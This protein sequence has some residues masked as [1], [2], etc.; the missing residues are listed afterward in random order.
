MLSILKKLILSACIVGI[1]AFN[2]RAAITLVNGKWSTTFDCDD[3]VQD[4]YECTCLPGEMTLNNQVYFCTTDNPVG[5]ST[6]NSS[7]NYSG[8][9]GGKGFRV[10]TGDGDDVL[11]ASP[12]FSLTTDQSEI[13]IR[14]YVRFPAGFAWQ[15]LL[16]LKS[17][18]ITMSD[19]KQNVAF[20]TLSS[21]LSLYV[22]GGWHNNNRDSCTCTGTDA[23]FGWYAIQG[24]SNPL[25]DGQWHCMEIHLKS[26]TSVGVANG[27]YQAWVDGVLRAHHDKVNFGTRSFRGFNFQCNQNWPL[28]NGCVFVD[29]DD[30][31][32]QITTPSGRDAANN[33]MIGPLEGPTPTIIINSGIRG[34]GGVR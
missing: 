9:G 24:A 4:G 27:V 22:D 8:G 33:P 31:A 25:G 15:K 23:S 14:W 6:I 11:G 13:W 29:Y 7:G 1:L 26:N 10:A 28:N 17:I 34:G 5:R 19:G 3:W 21:S 18:Y 30:F 12:V 32:F 16:Y 20:E 2:G